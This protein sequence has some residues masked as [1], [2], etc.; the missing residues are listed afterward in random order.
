[1]GLFWNL[2]ILKA[3]LFS[4]FGLTKGSRFVYFL[5]HCIS[6]LHSAAISNWKPLIFSLIIVRS[7]AILNFRIL[8][9]CTS[10]IESSSK[11]AIWL[12]WKVAQRVA[13]DVYIDISSN[14]NVRGQFTTLKCPF[15]ECFY[16]LTKLN[17]KEKFSQRKRNHSPSILISNCCRKC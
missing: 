11:Y 13:L 15:T 6:L 1:M 17:I 8:L 5:F 9:F 3:R 16:F 2:N 14:P 12:V 10:E 7:A 4:L